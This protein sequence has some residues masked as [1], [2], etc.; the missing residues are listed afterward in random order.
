MKGQKSNNSLFATVVQYL[1][2]HS[3]FHFPP[4][5]ISF[6]IHIGNNANIVAH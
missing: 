3:E 1:S 4:Q 6:N 5:Y 2:I